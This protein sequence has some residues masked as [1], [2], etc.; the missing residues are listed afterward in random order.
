MFRSFVSRHVP[1][2]RSL[3]LLSKSIRVDPDGLMRY[4]LRSIPVQQ[5]RA[6][7]T[8]VAFLF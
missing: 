3:L 6:I 4:G 2:V 8:G 1:F 7:P 5:A